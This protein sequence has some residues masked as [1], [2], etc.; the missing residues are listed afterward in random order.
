MPQTE[1]G[2]LPWAG[3]ELVLESATVVLMPVIGEPTHF[4]RVDKPFAGEI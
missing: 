1:L 2:E 4:R 3:G